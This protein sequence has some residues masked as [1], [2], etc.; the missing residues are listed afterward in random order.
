MMMAQY[1]FTSGDLFS[2]VALAPGMF[3][4]GK[5]SLL[6]PRTKDIKS[7]KSIFEKTKHS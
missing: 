7:V 6:S 1:K 5:L 2:D 3:L 4:K